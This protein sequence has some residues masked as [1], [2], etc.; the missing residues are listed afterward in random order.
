MTLFSLRIPPAINR[1]ETEA[2]SAGSYY[3]WTLCRGTP[4][5]DIVPERGWIQRANDAVAGMARAMLVWKD[6]VDTTRIGVG[7]H[8]GLFTY[9]LPGALTDITPVGFAPG[10]ADTEVNTGYGGG[11]YGANDYGTPRPL[12][13]VPVD[14]AVWT[15]AVWDEYLVGCCAS[16]GS[17]YQ[18]YNDGAPAVIVANAPTLNRGCFVAEV[19]LLALGADGNPRKIAWSDKGFNAIWTPDATNQAGDFIFPTAGRLMCGTAVASFALVLTDIDAWVGVYGL[20]AVWSFT[21]LGDGMGAISQGA[22]VSASTQAFWWSLGGFKKF[23]GGYVEDLP[24]TVWGAIQEDM[25]AGQKAKIVGWMNSVANEV[26]W[27]YPS[28]NSNECDRKVV[29]NYQTGRWGFS[30]YD[31]TCG[32][33]RIENGNPLAIDTAGLLYDHEVGT[34]HGAYTAKARTGPIRIGEGDQIM[35]IKA[36]IPDQ[37]TLGDAMVTFYGKDRQGAA[38]AAYGPYAAAERLDL[39]I[40]ARIIEVEYTFTGDGAVGEPQLDVQPGGRR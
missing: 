8:L 32:C 6:N 28:E 37:R 9:D 18:Y 25:N 34:Y 12:T 1:G 19:I 30:D 24:C 29:F 35:Q 33:D 10:S 31:R 21:K 17:I 5:G 15:L 27:V 26:I 23:N 39:R 16:D 4:G 11:D 14:A 7:T 40:S 2:K 3:S 36:Y 22:L 13:D 38:Y 20:P